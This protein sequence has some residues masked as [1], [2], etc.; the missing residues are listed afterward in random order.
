MKRHY[1]D[2]RF[3][4]RIY[5]SQCVYCGERPTTLDHFPPAVHCR[6][7]FLLPACS[8]CNMFAGDRWATNFPMRLKHVKDKIRLRYKRLLKTPAWAAEEIAELGYS[9]AKSIGHFSL[10]TA[11]LKE[12]LA[13]DGLSYV[14]SIDHCGDFLP[15]FHDDE[16]TPGPIH[17]RE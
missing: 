1:V 4:K 8:E 14:A 10:K 9:I 7:G 16:P 2:D 6:A 3:R 5:G 11:V 17:D 12:R 13:W 15:L